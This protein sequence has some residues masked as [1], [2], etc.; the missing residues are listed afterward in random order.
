MTQP[1]PTVQ[2]AFG[3]N[4]G[5]V[6]TTAQWT[7]ISAYVTGAGCA[8]GRSSETDA[9]TPG[10]FN[11]MLKNR[12]RRFDPDYTSS[13]YYPNV[14]PMVRLRYGLGYMPLIMADVP[15]A[16]WRFGEASG[17]TAT[18]ELA[19]FNG[20]YT[21]S[22]TLG[23]T[24][25]IANNTAVTFAAASSQHVT[26][27]NIDAYAAGDCTFLAWVK[28]ATTG[29]AKAVVSEGS[30]TDA[31][32][33]YAYIGVRTD[34]HAL[35]EANNGAGT[36]YTITNATTNVCDNNW[37]LIAA[38][39]SGTTVTLYVDGVV[40]GTPVT[41][42]GTWTMNQGSIGSLRRSTPSTYWN[43]TLDEP[44]IFKRALTASEIL[45]VYNEGAGGWPDG[46]R[47]TG[48]VERWPQTWPTT[49]NEALVPITAIDGTVILEA[50]QLPASVWELE[51]RADSP[52]AWWKLADATG[53]TVLVD[54]T[55]NRFD[56]NYQNAPS[57]GNTGLIA[58]DT[59]T[60][61]VFDHTGRQFGSLKGKP[62][63]ITGFP[64]TI[65]AWMKVAS[66]TGEYKTL[67]EQST[68]S[69]NFTNLAIHDTTHA[70][71]VSKISLSITKTGDAGGSRW[72]STNIVD[73]NAIHHVAAVITN[74]TTGKIYV[75]GVDVT[76]GGTPSDSTTGVIYPADVA[77]G[78]TPDLD[79]GSFGLNGTLQ[80]VVIYNGQA[81]SAARI[82][83]HYNAG[84]AG[85]SGSWGAQLS[86]TR[87][88]SILD[89]ASWPTTERNLDA[90]NSTLQPTTLGVTAKAAA[91]TATRS[92]QGATFFQQDGKLRFRAR[93]TVLTAT[94]H[95]TA[96]ATFG[97]GGGTEIP[98]MEIDR[99]DY[100][101]DKILNDVRG[102]RRGGPTQTATD[103]TSIATYLRRTDDSTLR[104]LE[105]TTDGEIVDAVNWR[106]GHYKDPISRPLQIQVAPRT[107]ADWTAVVPRE[108]GHRVTLN[109]RP[110][111]GG[112]ISKDVLIERISEGVPQTGDYT[113]TF[114]V[115]L[116]DTLTYW[117]LGT[118]A[119]DVSTRLGY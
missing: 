91:D 81:L 94:I 16:Y 103:T 37:H 69:T 24:G 72:T 79:Y 60:A 9:F 96:Q 71:S 34:N 49:V 59:A 64:F 7:D 87:I 108:I 116:A 21:N 25:R 39:K 74:A 101:A 65:E 104:D 13:P 32:N 61:A 31:T 70:T 28:T 76:A 14:K 90:G 27:G 30:S 89:A 48:F 113:F 29:T 51:V 73:D 88:G 86:G 35:F 97:D 5:T 23:A 10:T 68:S 17:T 3:I 55:A 11:A 77:I 67:F 78:N 93:Q 40:E 44:A 105:V 100:S 57:L 46:W 33:N 85:A 99:Y 18:D 52:T 42:A 2:A 118:S 15:T 109:R 115:S 98:Y 19:A 107:V 22:P 20:T 4:P 36:R 92:E 82:L 63:P 95:T 112:T 117:I 38:T 83:A 114:D 53:S 41:V 8:R 66:A 111:G 45:A 47:F 80:S 43:G 62:P 50:A 75:D 84:K 56:L 102:N 6:P 26:F 12:D 54:A 106:L 119:L 110:P 1:S 58:N